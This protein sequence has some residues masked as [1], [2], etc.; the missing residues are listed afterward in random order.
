MFAGFVYYLVTVNGYTINAETYCA[1]LQMVWV[2]HIY[3]VFRFTET[4][5]YG[6]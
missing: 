3:G 5:M 1:T 4:A 6:V 2:E